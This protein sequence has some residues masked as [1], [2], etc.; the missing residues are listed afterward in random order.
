VTN[1]KDIR[2]TSV[3]LQV[4]RSKRYYTYVHKPVVVVTNDFVA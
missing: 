2:K 1:K 3:V 4:A